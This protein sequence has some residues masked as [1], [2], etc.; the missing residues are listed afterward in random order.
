VAHVHLGIIPYS[1]RELLN[2]FYCT[3]NKLFEFIEAE[4]PIC[5]NN[6]PELRQIIMAHGIGGVYSMEGS[7][8]IA[9]AIEDC[10][11]RH[12]RGEFT[13]SALRAARDKFA[14]EN[15]GKKL[16]QLYSSLGV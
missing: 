4:I 13:P 9:K 3:P 14:W 11:R 8:A 15:Q 6:L 16:L 10:R 1:G 5:A 7:E 2:N 12:T